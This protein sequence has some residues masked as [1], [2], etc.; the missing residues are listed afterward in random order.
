[1]TIGLLG[2]GGCASSGLTVATSSDPVTDFSVFR[3]VAYSGISDRGR[4]VGPSDSSPIR[5][6]IKNMVH[7]QLVAKGIQEVELKE[8]P[9]LLLHLFYGV[10]DLIRVQQHYTDAYAY[11]EPGVYGRL[12]SYDYP[13]EAYGLYGLQGRTYTYH[14]GTWVPVPLSYET[15]HEDYEGTLIIDLAEAPTHKLVWRAVIRGILKD[16]LEQNMEREGQGIA[17]AFKDYPP[18]R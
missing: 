14:D 8:H 2:A 18:Q 7:D 11:G 10:K 16:S 4:E 9:Q 13:D 5:L 6:R 1:M 12:G 15:T 17:T 3:T